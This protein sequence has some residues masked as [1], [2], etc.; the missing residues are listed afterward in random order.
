VAAAFGAILA[1]SGTPIVPVAAQDIMRTAPERTDYR[2]TTRYADVVAFVRAADA[3]S[4]RIHLATLGYT[5]EGRALP[6]AVIGA[7]RDASPESVRASGRT[8]V[9]LQGNIHAG[10]VEGK[11][12]LLMLLREIAQGRHTVWLDSLVLLV[13]PIYNADGNERV[14]LTSRGGQNGPVGGQGQRPNAQGFDLNRDH[15]KLESPE[16]RSLAMMLTRYDPHA[17]VDLHTTNGSRHAYHLTY[18]PP[19]HPNTDSTIVSLLRQ[20]WLPSI[21]RN[22]REK[23]GWEYYYYGNL[24]GQGEA[25]GWYTFDHRPRFNNNYIGLRNRFAILSEAY[26]YATFQD[27][28]QATSWFVEELLSFAYANA[29]AIRRETAR[30]DQTSLVGRRLALRAG[31]ERSA[32]QVEILMGEVAEERNPY[33]GQRM[34]RRLDVRRPERMWEYGTFRPTELERVPRAYLVPANLADVLDRLGAHGVRTAPLAAARQLRVERF[35][36][37]STTVA[38]QEFQGHRER[39]YFGAYE[40]ST[41]TV[42]AGTIVVPVDQPLGRLLFYLLEPRSDDG[43]ANWNLLDRALEGARYYP[44]LRTDETA[45]Q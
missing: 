37:D 27:R 18:A 22:I 30:A 34:L 31:A 43:F 39:T 2:E 24:Q 17:A 21:T 23:H 1:V 45:R 14:S 35:R 6:L 29:S 28:I 19:L 16:A 15:M 26:A 20:R 12:S 3:A 11:E 10:E 7:V 8:I 42:P 38:P 32:E 41:E 13:A 40:A 36:I 25:R 33:T 4:D 5:L 9:Y 44:I